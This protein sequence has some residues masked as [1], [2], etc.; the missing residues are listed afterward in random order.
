MSN[1]AEWATRNGDA[2]AERWQETDRVLEHVGAALNAAVLRVAPTGSFD[3]LDIGCGA[4]ASSLALAQARPD[5]RILGC[6]L[7]AAL[8][9]VAKERAAGLESI[10]F[11]VG[12]AVQ[13]AQRNGPFDL[14]LSRHGVM[15][16]PDPPSAFRAFREAARP[17]AALIFS[18]FQG[19]DENP[20][21]SELASAAAGRAL[22]PPGREP[23]GFAFADPS[24]V[25]GLLASAGWTP[26]E[27]QPL[28]FRYVAAEGPEA[29]DEALFFLAE[30]GPA[31]AVLREMRA[32]DRPAA[33][34]RMRAV[35]EQYRD[36]GAVCF[37]AAAW[38]WSARTA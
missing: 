12:D 20:W 6:D 11:E 26:R 14:F 17:G 22:P 38:I 2:W 29:V 21:A 34:G 37:P 15:F 23:S 27:P 24:Y 35:L 1:A 5:A 36:G 32:D 25:T 30:I 3:A 33:I 9:E 18:C 10:T 19:W 31:S 16:F 13:V 28:V 4:G 7:S 8:I